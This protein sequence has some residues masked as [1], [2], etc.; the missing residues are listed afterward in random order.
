[1]KKYT[2]EDIDRIAKNNFLTVGALKKFLAD[3]PDLLDDSPVLV[4]RI[5][6]KYFE[7]H[8]WGVYLK[9]GE[10]YWNQVNLNKEMNEEIFRRK[11][12]YEPEY[13]MENPED[14]M[15]DP[16]EPEFM[17]QYIPIWCPVQFNDEKGILFLDIHY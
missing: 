4:Q 9:K 16:E 12:G 3:H 14:Y 10:H 2:R 11:N 13:E 6:D 5:E 8:D 7:Y 1:M 17:D 15:L